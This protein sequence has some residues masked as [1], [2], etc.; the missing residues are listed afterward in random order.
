MLLDKQT[1]RRHSLVMIA[2]EA[3][4]VGNLSVKLTKCLPDY[5]AVLGQDV[6]WL[7]ITES[8][9]ERSAPWF[10]GWMFNTYPEISTLDHPRY[11]V[12]LQGCGV[13]ARQVIRASGS[14]P[15]VE[16]EPVVDTEAAADT[17]AGQD[18]FYVPGVEKGVSATEPAPVAPAAPAAEQVIDTEAPA[19]EAQAQPEAAPA[20]EAPAA[21]AEPATQ[22]DL[23]KMMDSGTY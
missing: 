7:D 17:P 16:S 11:D 10:S 5:G 1:N 6:A 22:E 8:G 12:Q 15:V 19:A 9:G 4:A 18:P 20:A 21:P 23:H 13:K 2:G 3:Q 14:A